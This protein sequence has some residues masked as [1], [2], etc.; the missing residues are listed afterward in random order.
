[1]HWGDL[2][3]YFGDESTVVSG[4]QHFF[5]YSYGPP[6]AAAVTPAGLSIDGGGTVGTTVAALRAAHP[7]VQVFPADPPRRRASPSPTVS[8]GSSPGTT[9]TDTVTKVQGGIGCGE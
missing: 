8:P 6:A 2:C 3:C 5:A 4:R 1:M 9:D 7:A